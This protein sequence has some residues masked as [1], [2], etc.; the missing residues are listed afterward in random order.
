M[1]VLHAHAVSALSG[2]GGGGGGGVGASTERRG[3]R[4]RRADDAERALM[5]RVDE[6]GDVAARPQQRRQ[7]AAGVFGRRACERAGPRARSVRRE[8]ER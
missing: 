3:E 8:R 4:P 6:R 1:P 7:R 5:R 2:G